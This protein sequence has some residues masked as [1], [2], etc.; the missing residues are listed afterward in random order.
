[1]VVGVKDVVF[2]LLGFVVLVF[3]IVVFVEWSLCD[4]GRR[5]V[6]FLW[7][8]FVKVMCEVGVCVYGCLG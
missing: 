7:V 3:V 4:C 5:F 8:E 1:M 6:V 2:L